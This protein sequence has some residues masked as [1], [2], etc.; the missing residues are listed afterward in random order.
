MSRH[1][2]VE[3]VPVI[4]TLFGSSFETQDFGALARNIEMR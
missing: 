3:L 4:A 1:S 2:A